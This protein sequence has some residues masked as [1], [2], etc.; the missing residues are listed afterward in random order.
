MKTKLK[1]AM[2]ERRSVRVLTR[3]EGITK[4]KI[5]EMLSLALYAPNAFNMQSSR[6]VVLL[7][8]E[9]EKFWD[10]T[11]DILRGVT[12][13]NAFARTEKK[14]DG[15]QGGNGTILFFE[16]TETVEKY[17]RDFALYADKFGQFSQHN[18]AILQ[19]AVW[20]VFE[21][22]DIAASLQHY[23]PLVDQAVKDEWNVPKEWEMVAQMPFGRAAEKP[24]LREFKPFGDIVKIYE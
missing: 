22:E 10:M 1:E 3:G 4:K 20:L 15:F 24:E 23:N 12:P 5:E 16:D 11:K 6:M 2:L 17:K 18:N 19:Y 13:P 21:V 9:H 7:D 14:M 8:R